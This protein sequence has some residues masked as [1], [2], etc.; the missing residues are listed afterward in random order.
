LD[1]VQC[2]P[3]GFVRDIAILADFGLNELRP[4]LIGLARQIF[5]NI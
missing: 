2:E 1:E 3:A 4:W 5:P